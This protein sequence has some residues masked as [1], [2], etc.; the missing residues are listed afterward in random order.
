MLYFAKPTEDDRLMTE[1]YQSLRRKAIEVA[2]KLERAGYRALFAGGCVRDSLRGATPKD[3]DIATDATPAVVREMFEQ[4]IAVGEAFGVI[5]VVHEGENFEVATFRS[6]GDYADGRHPESIRFGNERDDALRRDFTMNGLFM[7]PG[8]GEILDYV[9]GRADLERR[10]IRTIGSPHDRFAEDRLRMMRAVRFRANLGFELEQ[11]T[12]DAIRE[13]AAEIHSVSAERIG[14]EV[15][16]MLSGPAPHVAIQTLHDTGLLIEILPE[17]VALRGV[18]QP[19]EF[20]PEGDVWT[21][22]L[23]M[24]EHLGAQGAGDPILSL[25]VL[26]HD[27]GKPATFTHEEGDRIRFNGHDAVGAD[28]AAEICSRLRLS[29]RQTELIRALVR[30]HMQPLSYPRMRRA[31]QRRFLGREQIERHLELHRLD[32]LGSHRSLEIHDRCRH[33]LEEFRD[34]PVLPPPLI[35]GR[36]LIDLGL[37]PGPRFAEL[38]ESIRDAQLEDDVRTHDEAVALARDLIDKSSRRRKALRESERDD[39]QQG[40]ADS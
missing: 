28:I 37:T 10:L 33:D 35:S 14:D 16:S 20:H 39:E 8:S 26:L 18:E 3:F 23:L 12:A 30:E 15:V 21:H 34:E 25:A 1:E 7:E 6:D 40:D 22:T 4:T 29:G 24:L 32:C 31:R 36:D 2:A 19:P 5:I 27:I 11:E 38:L 9:G 13:H 17:V